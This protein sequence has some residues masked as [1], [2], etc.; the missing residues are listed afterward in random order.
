MLFGMQVALFG[1]DS[2]SRF[3]VGTYFAPTFSARILTVNGENDPVLEIYNQAGSAENGKMG[4]AFGITSGIK[5]TTN[6]SL[7]TSL[8]FYERG[9]KW[10][11]Q[12]WMDASG[13]YEL[14]RAD[15]NF[16]ISNLAV[17][18]RLQYETQIGKVSFFANAGISIEYRIR[19]SFNAKI[20][21]IEGLGMKNAELTFQRADEPIYWFPNSIV[22]QS[23]KLALFGLFD[24]GMMYHVNPRLALQFAPTFV[25]SFSSLFL[26][27]IRENVYSA[28]VK[29]GVQY[30]F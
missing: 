23:S 18:L 14:G 9:Y 4:H 10:T 25:Y 27:P 28:G 29:F 26:D 17:P 13:I 24:L 30:S 12:I 3:T 21:Y 19:N 15:V 16:H 11:N 1:Q 2:L 8:D 22:K 6:W 20:Y 5:L 7:A